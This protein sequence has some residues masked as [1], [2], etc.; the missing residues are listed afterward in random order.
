MFALLGVVI[1][2]GCG[3]KT[4][5][6]TLLGNFLRAYIVRADAKRAL[7]WSAGAAQEKLRGEIPNV[8]GQP[9]STDMPDIT[10]SIIAT[11]TAADTTTY[12]VLLTIAEK[13]APSFTRELL[14]MEAPT[15]GELAVVDYVFV[16]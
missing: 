2:V 12:D 9:R 8:E 4:P 14:V 1:V 11:H 13:N 5:Q 6:E 10:Y 3:K 7:E 15:G 16:K